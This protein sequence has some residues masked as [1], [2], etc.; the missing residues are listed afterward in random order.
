MR[1][2]GLRFFN[3]TKNEIELSYNSSNELFEGSVYLDEVSTGLYETA[4][5]FMLEEAVSQYGVTKLVKPIGSNT[6]SRFKCVFEDNKL[7]SKD[8]RLI[9]AYLNDGEMYVEDK[10][11]IELEVQ[12][13]SVAVSTTDGIHTLGSSYS[14]EAL[15]FTIAL[16]SEDDKSHYRYLR[17][18]DTI[19]DKL[20]ANIYVYGETVGEDERLAVLLSNFG[21]SVTA[22]DQFL[23]KEH[24]IN[25]IGSDWKLINRKR[26]ELLLELGNIKPFV[27]TY[28]ALLNAIKFYGYNNLTLKEYWLMIDDRSP[29]FGKMKAIEV[30]D[31]ANGYVAKNRNVGI[32]NASY[33]KT[34][35]FGLYYKLNEPTGTFDEWDTP[36]VEEVFDFTP[37]EVLI[38]LYGLKNKLQK[39]YLPLHAKI[40]DIIGEG[41]F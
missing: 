37:E 22:K 34:S 5:I 1:Y 16:N 18:Y 25:E 17:I 40:I 15:Q 38:K 35:R 29:M 26:K 13:N 10:V 33:K 8:I 9:S 31:A 11:T 4:T 39:D 19:D 20:V 6:G 23:F 32:P 2:Q 24:D 28:K 36:E 41:D 12:D 14:K 27:G 21:T 30:P 7:Q 3:G